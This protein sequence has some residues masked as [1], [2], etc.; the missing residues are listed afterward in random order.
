ME[1]LSKKLK[2]LSLENR[3]ANT[4]TLIRFFLTFPS[5]HF[6]I[7][8]ELREAS[9]L[10]ILAG[11]TDLLDGKLSKKNSNFGK[12]LDPFVD[13]VFVLSNM[14]A[15][16]SLG[17]VEPWF[18]ILLTL[19]ELLISF[20]RNFYPLEASFLGKAKTFFEFLLLIS[21]SLGLNYGEPL[22][23]LVLVFAYLSALDYLKRVFKFF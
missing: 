19:R 14:I 20:L 9:L 8:N 22:K 15:F 3:L 16:L 5:A 21:L 6:V 13:K 23:F 2:V 10:I 1:V 4:L 12:L 7:K 11:L 18:L 17:K